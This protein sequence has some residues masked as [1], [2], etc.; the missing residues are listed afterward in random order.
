MYYYKNTKLRAVEDDDHIKISS[1]QNDLELRRKINIGVPLP[2]SLEE[3]KDYKIFYDCNSDPYTFCIEV[4]KKPI[5]IATLQ[6]LQYK[7]SNIHLGIYIGEKKER[8]K[9]YA[10]EALH[11]LL[12]IA[13]KEMNL[14]KIIISVLSNNEISLN[15]FKKNKFKIEGVLREEIYQNGEYHDLIRM[16]LLKNEY[17]K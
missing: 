5:G 11:M 13:F 10:K 14:N 3:M 12:D 8:E 16:G 2:I 6:N 17:I 1:W 15:F 4:K 9:G 7:N